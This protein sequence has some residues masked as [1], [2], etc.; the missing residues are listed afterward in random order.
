M[1]A[2][3][4]V[5]IVVAALAMLAGCRTGAPPIQQGGPVVWAYNEAALLKLDRYSM[6][7]RVAVAAG[8][9][10][11]SGSMRYQQQQE[12]ADLSIDGPLGMGGMRVA[13][14]GEKVNISTSRGE[15]LEGNEARAVLEQRLGFPLPLEQLRWWLLGIPQPK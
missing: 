3:A 4:R 15:N 2:R 12:R 14:D 6:S 10:G 9:Q 8:D 13:L 1:A 11:F 5:A 7:G